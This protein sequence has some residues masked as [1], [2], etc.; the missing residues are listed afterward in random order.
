MDR[1]QFVQLGI[2]TPL[3]SSSFIKA[4]GNGPLG[5]KHSVCQWCFSD[6]PLEHL[7]ERATDLGIESIELLHVNQWE[8]VMRKGLKVAVGYAND[9][10]LTR[11]FNS[12]ED[13]AQLR[14]DYIQAID[15]AADRG[16]SQIICFSGNS[17]GLSPDEGLE[18]C[19]IGLDP[20]VKY[21]EKQGVT[22]TMELLNSRIDHKD[23]QCDNMQWGVSLVEK[24]G[25][26]NFKLLYDIYHMQIMEGDIIRTIRDN[27]AY[28]SHYHTAGVPGRHEIDD[29]QELNYR[30]IM[31]RLVA[32]L[33]T[34][35][36]GDAD[37]ERI[38]DA[39]H[40][41]M[42]DPDGDALQALGKAIEICSV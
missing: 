25:S 32:P 41:A 10:G 2:A 16:V 34:G 3:F 14:I 13:H 37:A 12:R 33:L 38:A 36:I 29:T 24:L 26:E 23:Y 20:V 30:A 42:K 18:N 39:R 21:A 15:A 8:T 28:I 31:D 17:N 4:A 7:A 22:I 6:V 35:E 5:I 19:A 11:G 40:A 9:W 27:A 1:R